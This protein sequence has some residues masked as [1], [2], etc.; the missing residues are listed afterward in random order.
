[1]ADAT[2]LQIDITEVLSAL[3]K[4]DARLNAIENSYKDLGQ[5]AKTAGNAASKAFAPEGG[6]AVKQAA[7]INKLEN[8]Y[9]QLK[10]AADTLKTALK[11]AYD[12]RAIQVYAK[13]LKNAESGLK[14][15][16]QTGTAVGVNLKKIGK[17][18]SAAAQVVSEAFG[19]ITKATVILA[20]IDQVIK[21]TKTAISLSIQ[22]DNANRSFTAFTGN[23]DS[24]KRLVTDL[25]GLANRKLIDTE[26]V[27]QAAKSLLAFGES[28]KDLPNVLDRIGTIANATGK[29]FNDLA[30]IYGKARTSGVLFA[31]DINQLVDA[32]IPVIQEFAKQ[33]GVSTSQVK[34]LASEGKISFEELQL[35]FF[36]LSKEGTAFSNLAIQQAQTLPGLWA[37]TTQKVKPYLTKIG[38]FF[39]GVLK[40]GLFQVNQYLDTFDQLINGRTKKLKSLDELDS[41][42]VPKDLEK[43]QK[44]SILFIKQKSE[45][46]LRLEAE[47][48]KKRAEL[49]TKN[50]KAAAAA[51]AKAAKDL[52]NLR[53]SA[54]KEGE[55]KE[56]AEEILR[57]SELT[58]QLRR[59][60]LDTA[61]ATEQYQINVS[62][63]RAKFFLERLE[64]QQAAIR[65]EKDSIKRGFDE[66]IQLEKDSEDRRQAGL[67]LNA[68]ARANASAFG[69]AAFKEAELASKEL[70]FQKKRSDQ[71]IDDYEK[72]VA[73]ARAIFQLKMQGDELQR[74]LDFDTTLSESEK[75]TL[76]KRIENINTEINQIATGVG[77]TGNEGSKPKSLIELLGFKPGGD[78]DKSLQLAVSQI[79][80]ALDQITE[81]RIEA[82]DAQ[83]QIAD[84]AV[85]KA[86]E[87]LD[88][89]LEL[90]KQGFSN[91]ADARQQDLENAKQV[92]A[93]AIEEQRK[94]A[95]QKALIDA[96]TQISGIITAGVQLFSATASIPFVGIALAIAGIATMLA[97]IS[98]LKATAKGSTQ[99]REGTSDGSWLSD[100]GLIRGRSHAEGGNLLEVERGELLRV[101]Q[102]GNKKRVAIVKRENVSKYFDLL[103]A[104]NRGDDNALARHAFHLSG[105][106]VDRNAIERRVFSRSDTVVIP[107]DNRELEKLLKKVLEK[108]GKETS[109]DG[110]VRRSGNNVTYY[111]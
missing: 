105:M 12:P 45:E 81:A 84:D 51:A 86:E 91:N 98:R 79:R 24:A 85:S 102:D 80:G 40:Y 96:A 23:A 59:F 55:A 4:Y 3:D 28:A 29:D 37:Q 33:L 108:M 97:T 42:G 38:D 94:A 88:A 60:G 31:E 75:A 35:A 1:M 18:G 78:E 100:D 34:K 82:A 65:D 25:T 61:E 48:A 36:N 7:E 64:K 16:E 8:E 63:I 87:A 99:F 101:G 15:L 13:E 57:F 71:E 44:Q 58:K 2:K 50:G 70:F 27:F 49:N 41:S 39:S 67:A 66:L 93:Q 109:F 106:D 107:S 17:E 5:S 43:R 62:K 22:F 11:S 110:K 73:K 69:D 20:I 30:V 47:A 52:A 19:R 26:S 104:A 14:K 92:Q 9:R 21:L 6:G 95:R 10:G 74:A 77:E 103:D 72:G 89:E 54:M 76:K 111:K 90:Q 46:E 83:R 53:I 68:K 32:G 56:I